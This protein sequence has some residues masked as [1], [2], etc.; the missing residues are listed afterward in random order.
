MKRCLPI[1]LLFLSVSAHGALNKW[2]DA[3]GKVH[4]SDEPP[5]SNVKS[6]TLAIPSAASGVP[7]QKSIAER[8]AERKK[9]LK[10]KEEAAQKAAQ[11]QES[12]LA[13]QKNC[14]GAKANL[15]TLESH[16]PVATYNDKGERSLMDDSARQ[17][18]IEE[19]NRQISMYCN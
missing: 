12:E 4:Y 16:A 8:E 6:K 5:P 18:G 13:K 3:D 2:V 17:Q 14:A 10:A 9:S 19:A 11:Q 1:F 15:N 7:A